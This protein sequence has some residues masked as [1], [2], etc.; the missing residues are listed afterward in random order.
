MEDRPREGQMGDHR[1]SNRINKSIE[2]IHEKTQ[3]NT[4]P[5][6]ALL[7]GDVV[8]FINGGF[9]NL[10]LIH[11][12]YRPHMLNAPRT[13]SVPSNDSIQHAS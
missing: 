10:S 1:R 3:E 6:Q 7:K 12:R 13:Y 9:Q 5:R 4:G 11:G 8:P 2:E